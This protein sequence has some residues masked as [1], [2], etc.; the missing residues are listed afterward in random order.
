MALHRSNQLTNL[1]CGRIS[2][3]QPGAHHAQA[4]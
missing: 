1:H 4:S 2:E 3:A